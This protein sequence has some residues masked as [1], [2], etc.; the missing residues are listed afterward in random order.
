MSVLFSFLDGKL[1]LTGRDRYDP[2]DA[3]TNREVDRW[4]S[5]EVKEHVPIKF[6]QSISVRIREQELGHSSV[7][8]ARSGDG[9]SSIV[10]DIEDDSRGHLHENVPG[11]QYG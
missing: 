8:I 3:H 7:M 11:I 1:Q 6:A 5:N 10:E 4:S 2:P 9:E